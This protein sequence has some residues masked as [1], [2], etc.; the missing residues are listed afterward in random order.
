[1]L[2]ML[3]YSLPLAQNA[4][5]IVANAKLELSGTGCEDEFPEDKKQLVPKRALL[6]YVAAVFP[7]S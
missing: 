2:E 6:W 3:L 1:M 4:W 7:Y 5:C